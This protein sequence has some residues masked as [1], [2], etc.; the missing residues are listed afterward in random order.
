[1]QKIAH[2]LHGL[3]AAS[4]GENFLETEVSR[5][6]KSRQTVAYSGVERSAS[7]NLVPE[8]ANEMEK[9]SRS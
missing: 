4:L 5:L 3:T 9:E 2:G 6:D 7:E 1:M 8:Q